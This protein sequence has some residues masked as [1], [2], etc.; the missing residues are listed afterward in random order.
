MFTGLIIKESLSDLRLWEELQIT[1]EE[2][3]DIKNSAPDQPSE[4]HVAWFEVEDSLVE[5]F[6]QKLSEVLHKGKW[7]VDLTSETE[8]LIVFP[9]KTYR[10]QKGDKLERAKAEQFGLAVGIPKSQL[11]WKED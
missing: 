8:K 7:Y 3:W 10:Y 2:K 9:G 5:K 11:D 6:S 1:R 4:W